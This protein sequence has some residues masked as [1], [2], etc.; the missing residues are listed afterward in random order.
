MEKFHD[1][2]L[3]DYLEAISS[4]LNLSCLLPKLLN[5]QLL[6]DIEYERLGSSN[7]TEREKNVQFLQILRTKGSTAF[8]K[9]L[10]ALREED[11][12][13]GHV[14]LHKKLSKAAAEEPCLENTTLNRDNNAIRPSFGFSSASS[15]LQIGSPAPPRSRHS[16]FASAHGNRYRVSSRH[17]PLLAITTSSP[18]SETEGSQSEGS[19]E[20]VSSTMNIPQPVIPFPMPINQRAE[21]VALPT[22]NPTMLQHILDKQLQIINGHIKKQMSGFQ[23]EVDLKLQQLEEKFQLNQCHYFPPESPN[24]NYASSDTVSSRSSLS[25][26]N[27]ERNSLF[28]GS[29]L[30]PHKIIR[31]Y[32]ANESR[33]NETKHDGKLL[34]TLSDPAGDTTTKGSCSRFS[35]ENSATKQIKKQVSNDLCSSTSLPSLSSSKD[36]QVYKYI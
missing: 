13:L 3:K 10:E 20:S 27:S 35:T 16:Q 28:Y 12:H 2:I 17:S 19:S 18:S 9:F 21:A 5:K 1:K 30:F 24:A 33:I 23:N 8:Q 14:D 26:R 31:P 6:T 7:S 32:S 25:S 29:E 22:L 34:S 36:S 4:T 15:Q 11:E